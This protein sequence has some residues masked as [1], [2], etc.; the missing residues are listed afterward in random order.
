MYNKLRINNIPEFARIHPVVNL[1][2]AVGVL[3]ITMF[4]MNP[5]I[6]MVSFV[7]SAICVFIFY[8]KSELLKK[9]YMYIPI[10]IF[11]V[12]IQPV[13]SRTGQTPL[14]YINDNAVTLE[15]YIYGAVIALLLITVIQWCSVL[16]V[17]LN[18]ERMMYL[19]GR[20]VPVF[21]LTFSMILRY[22]PLLKDRYRQIHEA[23]LGMGKIRC[24]AQNK[25][26]T[27]NK[28]NTM[29]KVNAGLFERIRLFIKEISILISWSLESSIETSAS[30][31]ARGYGLKGRTSCLRYRFKLSDTVVTVFILVIYVTALTGVL[32]KRTAYYYLPAIVFAGDIAANIVVAVLTGIL[33]MLPVIFEIKG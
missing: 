23:Q 1:I 19:F 18:Q 3:T 24:N 25:S 16:R 4:T 14:Y 7:S 28:A 33:C 20:A 5:W 8:G 29:N 13:F 22:I 11:T 30:M 17:F 26:D 12:C 31:E 27:E 2:Y 9:F 32:S 6:L 15:A 21:G 10:I